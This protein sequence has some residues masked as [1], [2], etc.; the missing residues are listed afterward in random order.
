M[1][2]HGRC[3]CQPSGTYS[4]QAG[5]EVAGDEHV[6]LCSSSDHSDIMTLGDAREAEL[7]PW[8]EHAE[9]EEEEAAVSEELY[10]GTS[11]SSQYTFSAAETGR[12]PTHPLTN[13]A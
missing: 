10:L 4:L 7:G 13:P 6:T 11:S 2:P 9:V 12:Q 8:D 1:S 5:G 3:P